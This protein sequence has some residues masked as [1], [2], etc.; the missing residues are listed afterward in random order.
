M[1]AMT[2]ALSFSFH[3][4]AFEALCWY[5]ERGEWRAEVRA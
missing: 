1:L 4:C 3:P 5:I 2:F